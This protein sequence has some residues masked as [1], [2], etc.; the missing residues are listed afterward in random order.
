MAAAAAETHPEDAL[1]RR[2]AAFFDIDNTVMRG[3]SLFHVARGLAARRLLR[4]GEV[5]EFAWKQGKFLLSGSENLQDM[6]EVTEA[7]LSFVKGRRVEDVVAFGEEIFEERMLQKLWPGTLAMAQDHLDQGQRVW[8]VSATPVE[9]AQLLA[10]RLGLTGALGTV[11]ETR[12]G[13]YTGRLLGHPLHGPTKAEAV[14]ALAARE[15]LELERCSAYSDSANDIPLLSLVGFPC[16]VNPDRRLARHAR[17]QGWQ[18]RDYRRR[19][20][21]RRLRRPPLMISAANRF[22]RPTPPDR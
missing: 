11:A 22:G 20:R 5:A 9:I 18:I 15:G 17:K 2:A 12:D 1:D 14:R 7:A 3:A 10:Q 13:V 8:L 6:K 4:G 16:A 19:S 21:V